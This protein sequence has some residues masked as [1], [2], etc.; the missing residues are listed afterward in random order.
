M[1]GAFASQ[2]YD[3]ARVIVD[4]NY[5]GCRIEVTAKLANGLWDAHVRIFREP[6]ELVH[7]ETIICQQPAAAIAEEGS[8]IRARRWV[9]GQSRRSLPKTVRVAFVVAR[10]CGL[11]AI[12]LAV[13]MLIVGD[14]LAWASWTPAFS[15]VLL[16]AAV[17]IPRP[18]NGADGHA[19]DF[20]W[21]AHLAAGTQTARAPP[22]TGGTAP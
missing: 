12:G 3:V 21:A 13:A 6:P 17:G 2:G 14:S 9:D 16:L 5:R 10:L 20:D 4:R 11:I 1:V 15:L 18:R 22:V 19:L 7:V 8:I